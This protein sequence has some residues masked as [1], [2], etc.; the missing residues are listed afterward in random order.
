MIDV[1]GMLLAAFLPHQSGPY[2][3]LLGIGFL[4]GAYGQAARL[5]L[6]TIAG[7]LI[8]VVAAIAFEAASSGG[9]PVPP[10]F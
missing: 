9:A 5:P 2:L 4:V 10:G 3:V 1:P 6:I 8:V 7:I